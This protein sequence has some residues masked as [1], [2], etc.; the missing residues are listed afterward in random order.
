MTAPDSM[1]ERLALV[2]WQ[3]RA[4]QLDKLYPGAASEEHDFAHQSEETRESV[5]GEM[6]APLDAMRKP[7]DAMARAAY[8]VSFRMSLESPSAFAA[9]WMTMVDEALS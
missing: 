9:L 6:R 7:T 1:V 5:R 3:F 8:D 4:E 2:A